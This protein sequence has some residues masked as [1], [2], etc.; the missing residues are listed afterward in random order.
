VNVAVLYQSLRG[1]TERAAHRI[2]DELAARAATVGVYP[3]ANFDAQFVLKADLII[4]GTWTDGLFG[5]GAKPAQLGQLNTLP[6]I[7]HRPVAAFVT[8]E[9]SDRLSLTKFQKWLEERDAKVIA[10]A[11]FKVRGLGARDIDEAVSEFVDAALA[12]LEASST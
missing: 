5:I 3:V 1:G 11:G 4:I 6:S 8:Y 7:A 2:A 10:A 12:S 9:I